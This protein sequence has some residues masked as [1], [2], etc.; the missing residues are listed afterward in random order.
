M[1]PR[2]HLRSL[3]LIVAS[4][5][6]VTLAGILS[7]YL[8]VLWPLYGI[9]IFVAALTYDATGGAIVAVLCVA[10]VALWFVLG[11]HDSLTTASIEAVATT[12]LGMVILGA[13]AVAVG[14]RVRRYKERQSAL[15]QTTVRDALTGLY[16]FQCVS[17]RLREEV[18]RAERYDARLAVIF[19][20]VDHFKAFNDTYGHHKGNLAL[21][22]VADVLRLAARETDV[23]G[24]Y[25]GEEF[26]I[27]LPLANAAEA[28]TT[29]ERICDAVRTTPFEGDEVTP[30]ASLTVSCGVA[31]FPD[32]VADEIELLKAADAA[33]YDAK[34]RAT[35]VAV[36]ETGPLPRAGP[37]PKAEE[38]HP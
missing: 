3:L 5:A 35:G 24:R 4:G 9:S 29:A 19:I 21:K 10:M 12:A 36:A 18:R 17:E 23:M 11:R 25:G 33:M 26:V 20:D 34:R 7:G 8:H 22:R 32:A 31:V 6:F 15:E 37:E 1:Q 14:Y 13:L 30:S 28:T 16:N 27:I 2:M 38:V